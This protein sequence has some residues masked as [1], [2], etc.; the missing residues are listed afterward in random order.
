[1]KREGGLR[2]GGGATPLVKYKVSRNAL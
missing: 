2:G 1:M